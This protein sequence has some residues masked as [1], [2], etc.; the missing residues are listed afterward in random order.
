[1]SNECGNANGVNGV[2]GV[3]DFSRRRGSVGRL[4]SLVAPADFRSLRTVYGVRLS[5]PSTL[6]LSTGEEY[7]QFSRFWHES[8]PESTMAFPGIFGTIKQR[9]NSKFPPLVEEE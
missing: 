1:M 6:A 9:S 7:V 3:N 8:L 2:N 5:N 4:L